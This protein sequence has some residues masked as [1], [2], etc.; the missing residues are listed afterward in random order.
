MYPNRRNW[1][2]KARFCEDYP[3]WKGEWTDS[4]FVDDGQT[5]TAIAD[6]GRP[7][8][9]NFGKRASVVIEGW[10]AD[11]ET[12]LIIDHNYVLARVEY[13]VA[14]EHII[15]DYTK[16]TDFVFHRYLKDCR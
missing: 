13:L 12:S 16:I 11:D 14:T 7:L 6:F 3:F 5:R 1:N 10:Q 4:G 8:L 2:K 15:S 9:D